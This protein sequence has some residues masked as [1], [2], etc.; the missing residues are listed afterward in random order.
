M[1]IKDQL[2]KNFP[3]L[4][5]FSHKARG[6]IAYYIYGRPSKRLKV[7]GVT[8]TN[9][10]TT[11]CHLIESIL[12]SSGA[13]VGMAT[14]TTFKIG[15]KQWVNDTNFTTLNPFVLQKLLRQ[16][17]RAGCTYAVVE[18]SSHA[19]AQYRN[20]G[21]KYT[22]VAMTNV[23]H[24][25]LDYHKNFDDYVENKAK[26][27]GSGPRVSVVNLDDPSS[28]KF[29]KFST[30][31]LLT[32][33]VESRADVVARKILSDGTGSIFTIVLPTVQIIINFNLLG[34]FNI[35]N[36]LAAAATCFGLGI[37]VE[38]IKKGLEAV[39]N[40][41]GRLEK[42]EMGQDF[43]VIID[44]AVTPDSLEKL[45]STLRGGVRGRM[46]AVLGSCGDRDKTKRPIMGAIAGRYNDIVIVTDEEPYTEDPLEII[47]QVASGVPRGTKDKKLTL[48]EDYFKIPDRREAIAKALSMGKKGDLIIITGMGAQEYRVVGA[49]KYPWNE[50]SV[51]KEELEKLGYN[52]SRRKN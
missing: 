21:I 38:A 22:A 12:S 49:K 29:T 28:A 5:P 6:I 4:V 14:T 36:A 39:K 15:K 40:I 47:E 44:Y 11:T 37:P 8:G 41:P 52:D 32:Y 45:Y 1:T 43:T 18:T 48:D 10:K 35:S 24:E 30:G 16:M 17:V 33:S 50:S 27:F 26:L 3:A 25:H 31:K 13:T 42:V 19:I 7:I 51:I 23:T 20:W 9:G 34:K 46:I 2:R